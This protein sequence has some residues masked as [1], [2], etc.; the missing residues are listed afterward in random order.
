MI[1][2]S[3]FFGYN[4]KPET[5]AK[6]IKEYGFDCVIT[7]TDKRFNKQNGK[8]KQQVKLF[9]KHDIKLSSLHMK[10]Q[11]KDL[12]HFWLNGKRGEKLVK[13]LI[14]DI[15]I[16]KKYNFTCL[17]V[18]LKGRYTNIGEERLKRVLK[19]C[20]KYN[21]DLA[22]ENL[23]NEKAFV[24]VFE[25]INH[26]NLKFCYDSG[27]HNIW[28]KDIDLLEKYGDKLVAVHLHSNMGKFDSHSLKRYGNIDWDNIAKKLAKLPKVN[29]DY[30]LLMKDKPKDI[31]F[32]KVLK[33][34]KKEADYL[35]ERIKFY[36]N[37]N[38]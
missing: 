32:E 35:E 16:V 22:V 15:K 20:E 18:H 31:T 34:C 36:Q 1:G 21:I 4:I 13:D 28:I 6:L 19:V 12:A 24:K 2:I 14:D 17:V 8:I 9:K 3:W 29:L 11:S 27:H 23:D 30:E 26:P 5:R 37:K 33:E 25:N 10:Y 38:I 7:N